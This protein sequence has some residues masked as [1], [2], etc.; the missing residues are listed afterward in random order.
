MIARKEGTNAQ[1]QQGSLVNDQEVDLGCVVMCDTKDVDKH[2][3]DA[4]LKEFKRNWRGS[5]IKGVA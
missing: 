3:H 1:S 4:K 2:G 5:L